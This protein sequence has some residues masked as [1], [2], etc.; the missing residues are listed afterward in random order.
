MVCIRKATL[1]DVPEITACYLVCSPGED[2]DAFLSYFND[3]MLSPVRVVFAAE[4][5]GHI[6]GY[7]LAKIFEEEEDEE[8]DAAEE[9]DIQGY[10]EYLGVHPTYRKLGI[11]TKLMNA[12]Q[13]ALVQ[14]YGFEYVYLHVRPSNHAAISLYTKLLGYKFGDTA[15]EFYYDGEDAYLMRKQLPGKQTD[16]LVLEFS[17]GGGCFRGAGHTGKYVRHNYNV[18]NG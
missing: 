14:E 18:S 6:V 2:P 8:E 15:A 17:H 9:E 11:A 4:Y 1:A 10:I 3:S 13:N 12:A 7:V 16:H 5:D